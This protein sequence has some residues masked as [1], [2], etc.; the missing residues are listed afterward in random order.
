M[1]DASTLNE[2]NQTE[3]DISKALAQAFTPDQIELL[4][5]LIQMEV[6]K[7]QTSELTELV[8]R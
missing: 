1:D 8:D 4:R 3:H 7:F 2:S 6:Q 5:K